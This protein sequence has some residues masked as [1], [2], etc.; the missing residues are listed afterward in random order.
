MKIGICGSEGVVGSACRYGFK[1]LGHEVLSH[2]IVLDSKLEDLSPAEIIFICVPTPMAADCSC[3]TSVVEQVVDDLIELNYTG[4][5]AIKS[6]VSPG[7]TERLIKKVMCS[8]YRGFVKPNVC[9][10]PEFLRER[11]AISDFTENH[12][13]LVIGSTVSTAIEKIKKA[14][15]KYPKRTVCMTQTEAELTKYFSNVFNA[16]RVVFANGFYEVCEVIGADY[17][18][19]KDA[20]VQR[21]TVTDMYLDCNNNFRGFGGYCLPKDSAAFAKLAK[22]LGISATIFKAIVEDNKLYTTTVYDGMRQ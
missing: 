8:P 17:S 7:T 22:D 20:V 21:P 6:T 4:V 14:H 10:V 19:I 3:D 18:K 5:I 11:C 12:D 9:F 15:G 16:L 2:D 13:L 1:K